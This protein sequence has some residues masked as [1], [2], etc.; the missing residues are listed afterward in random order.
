[1]KKLGQ[2]KHMQIPHNGVVL[3]TIHKCECKSAELKSYKNEKS[4]FVYKLKEKLK[5]S[6]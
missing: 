1:M 4:V 2:R 3:L 5:F 6:K